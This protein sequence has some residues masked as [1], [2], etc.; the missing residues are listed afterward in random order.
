MIINPADG[1]PTSDVQAAFK[2]R[3]T[4]NGSRELND[5][6]FPIRTACWIWQT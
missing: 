3:P 6:G 2:T 1:K 4:S 5:S